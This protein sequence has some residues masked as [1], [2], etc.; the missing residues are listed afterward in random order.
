MSDPT[1][2]PDISAGTLQSLET[3]SPQAPSYTKADLNINV[4]KIPSDGNDN[5][6]ICDEAAS[7]AMLA[8][9]SEEKNDE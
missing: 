2:Q 6:T 4:L 3:A 1:Y 7:V 5:D 8:S 9:I